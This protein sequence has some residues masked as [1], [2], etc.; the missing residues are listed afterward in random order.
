MDNERL[1]EIEEITEISNESVLELIR[2]LRDERHKN[3]I[4]NYHIETL[5]NDLI[6]EQQAHNYLREKLNNV[7]PW[8][9]DGSSREYFCVYCT[10]R[11]SPTMKEDF[12]H[13]EDCLLLQAIKEES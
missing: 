13:D 9:W 10:A 2:E 11:H 8:V 4:L 3:S 7:D 1:A 12:I 6:R 5:K